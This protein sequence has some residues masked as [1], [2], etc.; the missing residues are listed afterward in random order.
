MMVRLP[1]K[2][3][4]P[5]I[6]LLQKDY[7][8]NL[9]HETHGSHEA[10]SLALEHTTLLLCIGCFMRDNIGFTQ[11]FTRPIRKQVGKRVPA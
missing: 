9:H 5:S 11:R 2:D 6:Y 10:M 1:S 4:P 3:R 7:I 8:R